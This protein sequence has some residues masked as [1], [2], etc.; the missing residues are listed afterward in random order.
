V[1][2]HKGEGAR[3]F[4]QRAALML[5]EQAPA[6]LAF[7]SRYETQRYAQQSDA[8]DELSHALNQL[9]RALPWRPAAPARRD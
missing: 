7:V 4:A 5:P 2:R 6:I 8:T 3:S 1:R 9:R